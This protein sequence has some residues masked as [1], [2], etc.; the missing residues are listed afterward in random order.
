MIELYQAIHALFTSRG[1]TKS[2]KTFGKEVE[3]AEQQGDEGKAKA[4][5]LAAAWELVNVAVAM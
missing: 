2:A 5:K 4:D 1:L 3:L